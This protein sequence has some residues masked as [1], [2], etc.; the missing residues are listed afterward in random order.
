M[1]QKGPVLT[2]GNENISLLDSKNIEGFQS[3]ILC[4]CGNE[5]I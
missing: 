1:N 4:A 3:N 2:K 5:N